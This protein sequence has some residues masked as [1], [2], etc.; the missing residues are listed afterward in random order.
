MISPMPIEDAECESSFCDDC[1]SDKSK[2][3][4]W[5]QATELSDSLSNYTIAALMH[6]CKSRMKVT[7]P[8]GEQL[9]PFEITG[10]H[11]YSGDIQI[12][13]KDNS[14]GKED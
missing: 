9:M 2:S 8:S 13:M 10:V 7:D 3:D 1:L 11:P 6:M 4:A 5:D 12:R 14:G